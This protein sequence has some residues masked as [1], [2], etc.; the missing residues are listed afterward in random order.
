MCFQN[1][2]ENSAELAP[3]VL[4]VY[5]RPE[6]TEKVLEA[7]SLNTLS[8][9]STLYV[10]S[11]GPKSGDSDQIIKQIEEVRMLV[12]S[13]DW[14]KH[15]HLIN[16]KTNLGLAQNIVSGVTEVVGKYGRVIVLEDD[17]I[18]SN[19]FLTYMNHSLSLYQHEEKVMHVSGYWFPLEESK[20]LKQNFFYQVPSCWGWGTWKRAW[21]NYIED[22][23]LLYDNLKDSGKLEAFKISKYADFEEQLL[24]NITGEKKTWA[25]KWY[26]ST[27]LKGGINLHPNHSFVNNIGHDGSGV[28]SRINDSF[29][30]D[31]LSTVSQ[32]EKVE[33]QLDR[34]ALRMMKKFYNSNNES[35]LKRI[36][37]KAYYLSLSDIFSLL[38]GGRNSKKLI[39]HPEWHQVKS[40]IGKG[41]KLFVDPKAFHGWAEMIEN[42]Y[43]RFMFD[44]VARD[45][46]YVCFDIGAHFGYNAM[47][48][49]RLFNDCKVLALEPNQFNL[50]QLS[51]HIKEN[52]LEDRITTMQTAV[53][54]TISVVNFIISKDVQGSQST[55]SFID[56]VETPLSADHY[57]S[58]ETVQ[59]PTTTIDALTLKTSMIPDL[60]KID[61][62]GAEFAVLKG[63]KEVLKEHGP[64]LLIEIHNV[65]A[66]FDCV[67]FLK[68]LGYS[69]KMI[70]LE[71]TSVSRGFI[72]ARID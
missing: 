51:E 40:G 2:P 34:K 48:F 21:D 70:D 63:G 45:K 38:R 44:E 58:F 4:F 26:A 42:E 31:Q 29:S 55:G 9:E 30:W 56:G 39:I 64:V 54:D 11:D 20:N 3:V 36:L 57:Q 32:C 43:D 49:T 67:K 5:N 15:V 14:C 1:S 25:I 22:A 50:Q 62:E 60:I 59:I 46:V 7:L 12:K 61:V 23:D 17:I 13:K 18:T 52:D 71:N 10:Y 47:M 8:R 33:L 24:M 6:H 28:N 35:M 16:R 53:S 66:M 19:G 65:T 69:I 37:R 68:E 72:V 41:L 27:F